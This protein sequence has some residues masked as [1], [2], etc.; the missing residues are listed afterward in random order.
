MKVVAVLHDDTAFAGAH[1]IEVRDGI[2]HIAGKGGSLALVDVT[3]L[4]GGRGGEVKAD[5]A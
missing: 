1:D 4:P 2:A 5:S 3:K